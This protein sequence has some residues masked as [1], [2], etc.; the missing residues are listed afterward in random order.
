MKAFQASLYFSICCKMAGF[1]AGP[2]VDEFRFCAGGHIVV[3]GTKLRHRNCE[4]ACESEAFGGVHDAGGACAGRMAGR[5]EVVSD[6]GNSGGESCAVLFLV[7]SL[8]RGR[9]VW[10][11]RHVRLE[12]VCAWR[13]LGEVRG[14]VGIHAAQRPV[15]AAFQDGLKHGIVPHVPSRW[16]IVV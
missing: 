4:R 13:G 2:S 5:G 11:R 9:G 15:E 7:G 14:N 3:G 10:F 6:R 12:H 16:P 8:G 1:F